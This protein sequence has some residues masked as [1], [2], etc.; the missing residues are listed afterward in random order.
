MQPAVDAEADRDE[1]ADAEG[2][3]ERPH[4]AV[5]RGTWALIAR[6]PLNRRSARSRSAATVD[7]EGAVGRVGSG[8]AGRFSPP[9]VALPVTLPFSSTIQP[10]RAATPSTFPRP[11]YSPAGDPTPCAENGHSLP[12]MVT[13]PN[14][15]FSSMVAVMPLVLPVSDSVSPVSVPSSHAS[16]FLPSQA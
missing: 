4:L 9:T 12:S 8:G 10:T 14:V 6:S 5:A 3:D 11:S 1:R 15:A 13:M 7:G 2:D 16:I